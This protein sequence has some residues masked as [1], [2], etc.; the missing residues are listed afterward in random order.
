MTEGAR[1]GW[2]EDKGE[3]EGEGEGE[4][5][6]GRGA[7]TRNSAQGCVCEAWHKGRCMHVGV[8][9]DGDDNSEGEGT[10]GGGTSDLSSS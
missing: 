5:L 1:E 2:C 3:G 6:G 10:R 4:R 7:R 9:W 8:Q